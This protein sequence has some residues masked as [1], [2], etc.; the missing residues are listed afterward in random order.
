MK[1]V[2]NEEK[3]EEMRHILMMQPT[4][5]EAKAMLDKD[6]TDAKA[7]YVYGTALGLKQD[8]AGS[9][10]AYS[11]GI[12]CDPF[13]A[14]NYFGRGRKK[15]AAGH[16]WEAMADFTVAIHL[17]SDNWTYWYYRATT[18]NLAGYLEES[19]DDFKMCMKYSDP[20]EHYP[21]IDWIYNTYVE[22]GKYEEAEK[23]LDLMPDAT[24]EPPQMDFGYCRCVR[25]FKGLVSPEEF[26]D[27]PLMERSVLP[28]ENRVN[29]ELNGMYY[30]LYSYWMVH[31][32]P[33]KAKDALKELFKIA[34]PGAFAH[35]K[36]TPIAKKLGII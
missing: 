19:I 22:M 1:F 34:Y 18:Q 24:I 26:I 14:P 20:H 8:Y 17:D 35:T 6:D 15:N 2:Y 27:I 21:L 23:A 10:E 16:F 7:W 32:E 5:E 3:N 33:E 11:R 31:G 36:A 28:R 4:V 12:A 30:G 29:L 13:Y 25:L 9:M